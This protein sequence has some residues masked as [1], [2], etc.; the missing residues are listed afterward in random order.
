MSDIYVLS[1]FLLALVVLVVLIAR[2]KVHPVATLFVVVV[3][4]GL[5]LGMG[6]VGTIEL[7]T[8]GFGNTLAN[9]GL[10]VIFGCV[11]GKMLELSGAAQT[12]TERCLQLFSENKVPWAVALA[13]SIV[14]IPLIA[15][16]VVVM[17]IPIVSA[18]AARTG[19]SMMKLGPI[20]Y[21]GAYVMTSVIPP[22]RARWHPPRC[23]ACRPARRSCSAWPSASPASS[24][25]R[26]TC[27]C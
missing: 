15:D 11:L 1:A 18:L 19:T 12:I 27:R 24:P 14:G 16:S 25:R 9:V 6:G 8:E 21:I 17:L 2:F 4:L 5:A 3:G 22:D 7:V 26:S 20:L 10:L 23:S 13:S